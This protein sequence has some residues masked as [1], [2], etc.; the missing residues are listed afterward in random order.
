MGSL[1]GAVDLYDACIKRIR[2]AGMCDAGRHE[3]TA[4][5]AWQVPNMHALLRACGCMALLQPCMRPSR[6][7]TH[8]HTR[9]HKGKFEFSYVSASA[10]IV[11]AL[12]SGR[13]TALKSGDACAQAAPPHACLCRALPSTAA[14]AS[15]RRHAQR[16][17]CT[18][19]H[20]CRRPP[21]AQRRPSSLR[22]PDQPPVRL[23]GPLP[24]RPHAVLAAAGRPGGRRPERA[25]LAGTRRRALLL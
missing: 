1:T 20:S 15:P 3:V 14:A 23:P 7:H 5:L 25:G 2:C 22:L 21:T 12:S 17:I 8:A 19:P 6:M 18:D 11:K 24:G 10:V 4:Q 9:R 16:I 13:R